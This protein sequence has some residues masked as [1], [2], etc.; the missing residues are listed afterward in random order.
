MLRPNP[1]QSNSSHELIRKTFSNWGFSW[2]GLLDNRNGEWLLFLQLS[3]ISAHLL[4]KWPSDKSTFLH[5]SNILIIPGII[6][7]VTG[8]I[9]SLKA[10]INLGTSLSPLPEPK[11]DSVLK[12]TGSYKTCRHPLYQSI[13]LSS[14]GVS[15]FYRSFL[16]VVL[17]LLLTITLKSKA[18][19]EEQ[20]LKEI[21]PYYK[22][23]MSK[24]IAIIPGIRFLDWRE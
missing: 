21:H 4:P 3:L 7:F 9:L 23:Y 10:F 20:K 15:L 14:L 2:G 22:D 19:R 5:W 11:I 18:K 17:L 12:T 1:Q 24:T 8:A 6:L 16:H 13:L